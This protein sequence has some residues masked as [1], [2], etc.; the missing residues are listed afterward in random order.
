MDIFLLP[1]WHHTPETERIQTPWEMEVIADE[2]KA[3]A[4]EQSN[5]QPLGKI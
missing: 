4:L 3:A 5:A 2:A 1:A